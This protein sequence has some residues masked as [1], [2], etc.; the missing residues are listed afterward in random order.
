MQRTI[1]NKQLTPGNVFFVRGQVGFSRISRQT[2]DEER[3]KDNLNKTYKIDKNYTTISIYNAQVLAKNPQAP[4]LEERYGLEGCYNSSRPADYP[5]LN[6]TALNKS[7]FLPKIGVL[8]QGSDPNN[9]P[10][11]KEIQLDGELQKGTDVT[12]VIRVFGG[13]G[14]NNGI[15]LDTV[16]INQSD[17]QYYGNNANVQN[18]LNDYG[19]TFNAMSPAEKAQH[20]SA[21]NPAQAP[22]PAQTTQASQPTAPQATANIFSSMGAAPAS[23]PEPSQTPAQGFGGFGQAGAT[24]FDFGAQ[25]GGQVGTAPQDVQF[26]VGPGRTY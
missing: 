2:T 18:A 25:N 19:I 20:D 1:M 13:Q 3:E 11:Y 24:P 21:K 14:G 12:L 17:F 7:Q 9:H 6:Y 10:S 26:G 4:T 8:E 23:T 16:L 15:S 22:A 5:G